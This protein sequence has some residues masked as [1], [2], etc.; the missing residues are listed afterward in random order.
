M[1]PPKLR[2]GSG[3]GILQ[4]AATSAFTDRADPVPGAPADT[5]FRGSTTPP[6]YYMYP[7]LPELDK[8]ELECQ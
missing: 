8:S 3:M 6:P 7:A 4:D 5:L 1:Q 2:A